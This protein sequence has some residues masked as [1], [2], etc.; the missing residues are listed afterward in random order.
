MPFNV[1]NIFRLV[2]FLPLSLCSLAFPCL[3]R[4]DGNCTAKKKTKHP[5][6]LVLIHLVFTPETSEEIKQVPNWLCCVGF[7]I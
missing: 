4:G 3:C 7:H 1:G 6:T 5:L 2:G